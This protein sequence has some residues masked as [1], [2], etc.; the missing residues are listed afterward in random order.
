MLHMPTFTATQLA[1]KSERKYRSAQMRRNAFVEKQPE[2]KPIVECISS[3]R[4][5]EKRHGEFKLSGRLTNRG[6]I[7]LVGRRYRVGE[8]IILSKAKAKF[9][10]HARWI[11]IFF[12]LE[13]S[14]GNLS[15][16]GRDFGM[17]HTSILHSRRKMISR[18]LSD[19]EFRLEIE[20]I[21]AEINAAAIP[22]AFA[23]EEQ[24]KA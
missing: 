21:R 7:R 13:E 12:A 20:Q 10:V 17:D 4:H 23:N 15:I 6:I 16:V 24:E 14:K 1:V 18:I 2:R 22:G 11:A 19:D 8:K 5:V 3:I 9:I